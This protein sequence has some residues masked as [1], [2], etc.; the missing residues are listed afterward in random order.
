MLLTE[1]EIF[2]SVVACICLHKH[3]EKSFW[4]SFNS[5][6][7]YHVKMEQRQIPVKKMAF[8]FSDP[9]CE[10]IEICKYIIYVYIYIKDPLNLKK[11]T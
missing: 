10:C 3:T 9:R 7:L 2:A 1:N 11:S 5:V 6:R 4:L 8:L